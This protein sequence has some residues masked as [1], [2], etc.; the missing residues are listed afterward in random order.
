MNLVKGRR[1]MDGKCC[2]IV[3]ASLF[4]R[5][6]TCSLVQHKLKLQA[7]LV[8]KSHMKAEKVHLSSDRSIN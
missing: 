5:R 2:H 7:I 6:S 8:D 4:Q 3:S 1:P